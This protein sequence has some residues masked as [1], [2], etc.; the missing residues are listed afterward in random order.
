MKIAIVGSHPETWELAPFNDKSWTIW[1]FSRKNYAKLTRCDVWFELHHPRNYHSYEVNCP[2]YVDWLNDQPSAMLHGDY[3][4]GHILNE[5]GPYF[6]Q[7]GQVPWLLALAITYGPSE[8]GLWGIEGALAYQPQRPEILH[9][10]QVARDEGIL[11]TAPAESELL[12][13]NPLYAFS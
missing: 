3:P 10:V 7:H 1:G 6:F 11:V 2:G 13:P 8:I 4:W 9:F 5:F 12:D